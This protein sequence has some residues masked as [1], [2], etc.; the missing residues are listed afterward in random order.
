MK[1]EMRIGEIRLLGSI[2]KLQERLHKDI[3]DKFYKEYIEVYRR[4]KR[5]D[6]SGVE[7]SDDSYIY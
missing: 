6:K 2:K 5:G 1:N 4:N 3:Q 7:V